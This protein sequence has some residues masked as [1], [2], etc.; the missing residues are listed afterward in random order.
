A[1]LAIVA[2][3]ERRAGRPN[4]AIDALKRLATATA[5]RVEQAAA[6]VDIARIEQER[7]DGARARDALAVAVGSEG[8]DGGAGEAFRSSLRAGDSTGW[9]RYGQAVYD[10][11]RRAKGDPH[12]TPPASVYIGLADVLS[13]TLGRHESA[14]EVLREAMRAHEGNAQ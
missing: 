7:G 2:R 13:D 9:S 8:P 10:H 6:Y 12:R 11:V 5:A 1:A 14:L 3:I 4:G